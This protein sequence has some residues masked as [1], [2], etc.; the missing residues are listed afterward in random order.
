MTVPLE[1]RDTMLRK[2][3]RYEIDDRRLLKVI[4]QYRVVGQ[5][6][7]GV[8]IVDGGSERHLVYLYSSLGEAC[9]CADHTF[10][11]S[12]CVHALAALLYLNDERVVAAVGR[13]MRDAWLD[14][15]PPPEQPK[16]RERWHN[17]VRLD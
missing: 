2:W 17:G 5:T 8:I 3:R 12:L 4:G 16:T 15:P 14:K 1:I 11:E 7:Q 10:R 6:A 9:D 13:V